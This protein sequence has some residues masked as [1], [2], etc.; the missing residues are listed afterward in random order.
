MGFAQKVF[1]AGLIVFLFFGWFFVSVYVFLLFTVDCSV[2]F[3]E[4]ALQECQGDWQRA[5]E[6]LLSNIE[7]LMEE[8]ENREVAKKMHAVIS[9]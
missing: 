8:E 1:F 6:W 2:Q 7:R 9:S 5:A 3:C 4:R